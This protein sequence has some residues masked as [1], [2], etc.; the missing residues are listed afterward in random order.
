[1]Q[2]GKYTFIDDTLSI[3]DKAFEIVGYHI[4]KNSN[5]SPANYEDVNVCL[6]FGI[7]INNKWVYSFYTNP[8]GFIDCEVIYDETTKTWGIGKD[9]QI[10]EKILAQNYMK[11]KY[12]N[13]KDDDDT[14]WQ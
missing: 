1:M 10:L 14:Q 8:P 7:H 11:Q 2:Y 4:K 3:E 9:P 5:I 6:R 13:R 12:D